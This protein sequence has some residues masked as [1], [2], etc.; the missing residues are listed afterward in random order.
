MKP[1]TQ[2][3]NR[4]AAKRFA[5][6]EAKPFSLDDIEEEPDEKSVQYSKK[7]KPSYSSITKKLKGFAESS[8]TEEE[9]VMEAGEEGEDMEME[10]EEAMEA[11]GDALDSA[12]DAADSGDIEKVKEILA[13]MQDYYQQ[14]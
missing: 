2:T 9:P 4:F 5:K 12:M 13:E 14:C 11:L 1:M 6:S 10:P 7:K 3:G 8:D